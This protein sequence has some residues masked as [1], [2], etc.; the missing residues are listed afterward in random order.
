MNRDLLKVPKYIASYKLVNNLKL[1]SVLY[2]KYKEDARK[3]GTNR[4]L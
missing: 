4:S 1:R 2:E 3:K